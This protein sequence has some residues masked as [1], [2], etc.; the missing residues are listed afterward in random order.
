MNDARLPITARIV[1]RSK[2]TTFELLT[3]LGANILVNSFVFSS[4][5]L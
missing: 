1:K 3:V 2:T 4:L 5:K